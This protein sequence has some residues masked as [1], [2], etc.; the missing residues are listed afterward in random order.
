MS[1]V[2][3]EIEGMT[4]ADCARHVRQGLERAGAREVRID[5]RAGTGM[6]AADGPGQAEMNRALAGTRYRVARVHE[7][8]GDDWP[9]GGGEH[10]YDL[11]VL[12]SGGGAFAAA[13]RARDLGRRVL[14]V[15]AATI[16][17]TCVNVGCIPSKSLLVSSLHHDGRPD[18]LARAVSVKAA[19]V[20]RLRQDKYIDLLDEYGIELRAGTA[21]L[22]GPHS[23]QVDEREITAGA[24]LIS[25]G[26]RPAIP[27]ID[28]LADAGYLT[29]TT[30]LEVTDAPARLAVIG[31]NAVGLE[32]GQMFGGFG[33][34]V[35]FLSRRAITPRSEP[36]I[37]QT[38]RDVLERQGHTVLEHAATQRV[39]VQDGEKVLEVQVG[40]ETVEVRVDGILV[41]TGRQPNTENLGLET[42]GVET[43][44]RGAI[45]VDEHQRTSVPSIFAAGD[46]SN[47]PQFVY[48]AAAGGAT[49]AQNALQGDSDRLEF[50]NLPQVIFTSPQIARAGLTEAEARE[51]GFEVRTSLLP[52]EAIPRALVNRD[53][54]GLF[55]LIAEAD[56]G[57]LLGASIIADS[58]AE[59]IQS[60][61]LAITA[62]LT[63]Q[64]LA[65]TWAPYLTMA[66]G[67]KLAAQAFGRDVATLS[68]CAA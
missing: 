25:T 7:P 24:I 37:S 54:T 27:P 2:K 26:A 46:V 14:M 6:T 57:R 33:T 12:G 19:L 55:K 22:T 10:D 4:C 15:E 38:I 52:L 50:A 39:R 68:C 13:I 41:A 20:K 56:T 42:V 17:G 64:E 67:L 35:T 62:G 51:R 34:Q 45:V 29:S 65:S 9:A 53:T 59:V 28:G 1:R 48:V 60:A 5:W 63:V 36:E 49:A 18:A 43:D 3:L 11:V 16:G 8:A 44:A 61:V 58:A 23:V 31:A 30:A 66:E 47:Q 32:L 21:R 40:S